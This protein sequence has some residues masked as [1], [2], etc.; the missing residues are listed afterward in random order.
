MMI[1]PEDLGFPGLNTTVPL[2]PLLIKRTYF[3]QMSNYAYIQQSGIND[4]IEKKI[5]ESRKKEVIMK[6]NELNTKIAPNPMS[7]SI[8]QYRYKDY[9]S[10]IK[11]P[12]SSSIM[13][14][15]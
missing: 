14:I 9:L 1:Y 7:Q 6:L 15:R 13:P 2:R 12:A 10:N 5:K 8:F 4:S 3:S 11:S